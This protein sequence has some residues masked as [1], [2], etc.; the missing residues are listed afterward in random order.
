MKVAFCQAGIK[1]QTQ[2]LLLSG[3][4]DQA[5]ALSS[6]L[7]LPSLN[8]VSVSILQLQI[9]TQK[10]LTVDVCMPD[11]SYNGCVD[12]CTVVSPLGIQVWS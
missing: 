8:T 10:A 6:L 7:L 2:C 4:T 12:I 11:G 3:F 9:G 1:L 5:N